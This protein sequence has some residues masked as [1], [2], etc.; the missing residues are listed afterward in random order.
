VTTAVNRLPLA[1]IQGFANVS[2]IGITFG[3]DNVNVSNGFSRGQYVPD[4]K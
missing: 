4:P 3:Y 2:K 1:D